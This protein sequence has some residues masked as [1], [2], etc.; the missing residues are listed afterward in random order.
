MEVLQLHKSDTGAYVTLH[1]LMKEHAGRNPKGS[2][3]ISIDGKIDKLSLIA[4]GFRSMNDTD[5]VWNSGEAAIIIRPGR[6]V[7]HSSLFKNPW[8]KNKPSETGQLVNETI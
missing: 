5:E 7:Y 3:A 6:V 8:C 2:D 4:Q 1:E